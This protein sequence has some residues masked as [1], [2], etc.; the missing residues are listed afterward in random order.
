MK[1]K[2]NIKAGA[3]TA[4][5][6]QRQLRVKT[7]DAAGALWLYQQALAIKETVLGPDHV[8]VA[9]TLNNLA[10]LYTSLGAYD[11]AAGC[12]RRALAIYEETLDPTHPKLVTCQA[13]YADLLKMMD[14]GYPNSS[15][16]T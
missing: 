6:N 13:N 1:T 4:N 12:Y 8:D 11:E 5:H 2:T 15:M 3:L 16:T 10:V 7:G 14:Q 9:L